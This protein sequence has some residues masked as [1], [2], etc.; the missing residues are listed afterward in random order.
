MS[1]VAIGFLIAFPVGT[2]VE[3]L[4]HRFVLHA[5][6]RTFITRQHRLH[7]KDNLA[8][9]LWADF[10]DFLPGM[11]PVGWLGF[12]HSP[13]A[14]F[15]FLIGCIAYVLVLALVHKLSHERPKLVFWMRPNSHWLHHGPSPRQN[16]GIVT[17][18]WDRM[19]GTYANPQERA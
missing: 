15:G 11:A 13:A 16:F 19:F 7:H 1:T 18:F 3:Y 6:N 5:R 14:G 8:D 2:L 9:P 10:R 12:L 17:R 4:I